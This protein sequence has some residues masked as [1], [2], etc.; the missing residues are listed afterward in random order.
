NKPY[1]TH[2]KLSNIGVGDAYLLDRNP[3]AAL[4][5]LDAIYARLS[6]NEGINCNT[7]IAA[8]LWARGDLEGSRAKLHQLIDVDMPRIF[9]R[10]GVTSEAD[11]LGQANAFLRRR[12]ELGN[13]YGNPARLN[14]GDRKTALSYLQDAVKGYEDRLL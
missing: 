14:L 5:A 9:K 11:G 8:A 10:D 3:L 2:V 7:S 1:W 6:R 12:L 13:L 4:Q